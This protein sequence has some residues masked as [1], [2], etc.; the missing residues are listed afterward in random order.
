VPPKSEQKGLSD[1]ELMD[2]YE[3]GKTPMK[4]IMKAMLKTSPPVAEKKSKKVR[5][6]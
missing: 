1:Q 4:K 5:K 2:K 6:R 3:S